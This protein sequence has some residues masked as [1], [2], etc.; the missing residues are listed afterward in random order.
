MQKRRFSFVGELAGNGF[1]NVVHRHEALQ[2]SEFIGNE[3][4]RRTVLA[5]IPH[6]ADE[7]DGFGHEEGPTF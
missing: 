5:Q 3:H 1:E 7:A 2:D 4:E 6:E